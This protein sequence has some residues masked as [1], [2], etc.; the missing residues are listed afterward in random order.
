LKKLYGETIS[1]IRCIANKLEIT[2]NIKHAELYFILSSVQAG[3][4]CMLVILFT[5]GHYQLSS[6]EEKEKKN[7]LNYNVH[8]TLPG[9]PKTRG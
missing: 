6:N 9:T 1:L 3:F 5:P 7:R 2:L 4:Q 8:K